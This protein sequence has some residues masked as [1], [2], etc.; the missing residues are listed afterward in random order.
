MVSYWERQRDVG[1]DQHTR[2]ATPGK[3]KAQG[4]TTIATTVLITGATGFVGG[5]LIAECA[6]R[7]WTVHGTTHPAERHDPMATE[8]ATIH[9][10][11][12]SD[13]AAVRS[14]VDEV[15]PAQI[16]HLAAQ[17]SVQRAWQDPM[18]TLTNN[19]AAQLSILNATRE[20][21]PSARNLVISS[22]EVYGDIDPAHMP[23]DEDAALGPRDPYAVSKVTQ[24]M[25]GL[26]HVLAFGLPVVR[27]RPFNHMGPR[28]RPGF[29]GADF[30]RQVARVEAGLAPP[31]IHVGK[32]D[33][34]RDISDVRD[35][36]RA[37]TLALTEG[38]PGA[39]YN[40]ASGRGIAIRDILQA[41]I[42]AATVPISVETDPALLRPA[43]RPLI[44][45]DASRLHRRT[46]WT[47]RIPLPRTVRDT[48]DYWREQVANSN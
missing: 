31:V 45:G 35:V 12:L 19:I 47:P 14:L 40:V 24:E 8:P 41:F 21:C 25:L 43:D 17:A 27:V 9:A 4:G 36:V 44:V 23:L 28:Q 30:A 13:M 48:L 7:G 39:V 15:R 46:G 37:Y 42:D 16:Y 34:M 20:V 1:H 29:V 3:L 32:L 18:A 6:R 2:A 33:A 10:V 22:S 26:Q 11:E 38:E 5:H